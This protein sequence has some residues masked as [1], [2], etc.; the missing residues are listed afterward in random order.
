MK[1]P[2][3]RDVMHTDPYFG[4]IV[5]LKCGCRAIVG[6]TRCH[7]TRCDDHKDVVLLTTLPSGA[8]RLIAKNANIDKMPDGSVRVVEVIRPLR[9]TKLDP[10]TIASTRYRPT[11]E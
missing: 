3:D 11:Q 9:K 5:D 6:Q 8:V 4:E 1:K 2:S 10:H 7:W